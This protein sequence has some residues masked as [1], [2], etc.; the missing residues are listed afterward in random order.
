MKYC[1][2]C[3]YNRP[4]SEFGNNKNSRDGKQPYCLTHYKIRRK[5]Y[6]QTARGK[7]L[8]K[9]RKL[10]FRR[11]GK[12]REYNQ[13]YYRTHRDRI[14]SSKSVDRIAEISE[15][16]RTEKFK[17]GNNKKNKPCVKTVGRKRTI[18][19]NPRPVTRRIQ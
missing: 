4:K 13:V 17:D 6:A 12:Q 7:E 16:S 10:R 8:E 9:D 2:D 1:P 15:C 19:L 5:K 11:S 18:I 3:G 14:L